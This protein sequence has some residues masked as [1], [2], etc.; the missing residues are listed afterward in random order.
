[1]LLACRIKG[2]RTRKIVFRSLITQAIDQWFADQAPRMGAALAFYT[3][4]SLAPILVM[5]IA[6]VGFVLDKKTAQYQIVDQIR[7][8]FGPQSADAVQGMIEASAKHSSGMKAALIGVVTLLAGATGALVELQEGLNRIWKVETEN[9]IWYLIKQRVTS[10][11]LVGGIGFLLLV[12]M[13]ISALLAIAGAAMRHQ[14]TL[15]GA[16]WHGAD[17]AVS[18]I[19]IT[20]LFAMIFK[21]LP[22]VFVPWTDV[23]IGAAVTAALFTLGKFL[24][25]LYIGKGAL[26]STYGTAG[27]F[28]AVLLWVYYSALVLYFGAEFTKAYADRY[29]SRKNRSFN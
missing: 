26:T 13:V 7:H 17:I 8:L 6:V 22:E 27:S 9:N 18:C 12:S 3:V 20:A 5:A 16:L 4:F 14:L 28:V 23:W 29:G 2:M 24:M 10:L 1:M 15:Q 21:T 19:V 25:A 11:A